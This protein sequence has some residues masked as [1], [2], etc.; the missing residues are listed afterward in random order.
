MSGRPSS[1]PTRG[2][3]KK[4]GSRSRKT[5]PSA[6]KVTPKQEPQQMRKPA[7]RVVSIP[8]EFLINPIR[9]IQSNL[10]A[11][12]EAVAKHED[13]LGEEERLIVRQEEIPINR[14]LDQ[15]LVQDPDSLESDPSDTSYSDEENP[16][17]EELKLEDEL[18]NFIKRFP[19]CSLNKGENGTFII[20]GPKYCELVVSKSKGKASS[21]NID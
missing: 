11:L 17:D 4:L 10:E 2:K 16:T 20:R 3:G 8:S 9:S 15:K 21:K 18:T 5:P 1:T 13:L 7:P 14:G 6:P 12:L 19:N